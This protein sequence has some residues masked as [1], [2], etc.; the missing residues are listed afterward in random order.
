MAEGAV[1]LEK[2]REAATRIAAQNGGRLAILFGS[3]ARGTATRR[4]DIDLIFVDDLD[5]PYLRRLDRYFDPLADALD[6]PIE[7]LVY[8]PKEFERMK[9]R[10]FVKRALEEGVVL[11]ER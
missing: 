1:S 8:T 9:D 6:A 3:H 2:I 11:Y 7:V 5:I 10:S 4:S